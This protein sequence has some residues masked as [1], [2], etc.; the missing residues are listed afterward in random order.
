M[1]YNMIF[2]SLLFAFSCNTNCDCLL[3]ELLLTKMDVVI[4]GVVLCQAVPNLTHCIYIA[5]LM[6]SD[7]SHIRTHF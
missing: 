2:R 4:L 5:E 3:L 6:I 1:E 7:T